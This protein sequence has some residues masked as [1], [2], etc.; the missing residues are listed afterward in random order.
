M[1]RILFIIG[2]L[3]FGGSEIQL[4]ILINHLNSFQYNIRVCC[5]SKLGPIAELIKKLGIITYKLKRS[6]SYDIARIIQIRK[7]ILEFKPDIIHNFSYEADIY[8]TLAAVSLGCKN[9]IWSERS[10]KDWSGYR[11]PIFDR[12]LA[13]CFCKSIIANS[14][15]GKN[16][17]NNYIG[18]NKS[19]IKVIYNG[20][21]KINKQSHYNNFWRKKFNIKKK[22]VVIGMVSNFHDYK[23]HDFAIRI[24]NKIITKK[25]YVHVI[26]VGSGVLYE[27]IKKKVSNLLCS[28]NFYFTGSV[29]EPPYHE[30]DIHILTSYFEGLSNSIL[31]SMANNIP[32]IVTNVGGNSEIIIN[33]INGY[34]IDDFNEE[35][36]HS[37]L[38][39][40][41]DDPNLR[42]KMGEES[43]IRV[44]KNFSINKMVALYV[45][46]YE[47]LLNL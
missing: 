38:E 43:R 41:I 10:S 20:I 45:K 16:F 14:K 17:L 12:I 37:A 3:D 46:E 35:G 42:L 28:K 36:F 34:L 22:D 47:K 23:N 32:N 25:E 24:L 2:Q 31:E 21:E 11:K 7:V 4:F 8:G 44:T 9:V 5:L 13:R 40:L 26:F 19:T 6:G 15:A 30:F 39:K 1:L 27:S 18:I 29:N 33:G